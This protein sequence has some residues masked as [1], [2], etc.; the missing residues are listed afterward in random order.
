MEAAHQLRRGP[1]NARLIHET[2][3]A[4]TDLVLQYQ[5]PLIGVTALALPA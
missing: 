2:K 5:M 1:R 3:L 4:S